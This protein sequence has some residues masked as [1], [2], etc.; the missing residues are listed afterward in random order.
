MCT[1]A[2]TILRLA[3]QECEMGLVCGT[4]GREDRFAEGF[5]GKEEETTLKVYA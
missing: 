2:H 3:C 4:Y 1:A 5:G